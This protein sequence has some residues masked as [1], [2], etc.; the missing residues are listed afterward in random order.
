ML[1]YASCAATEQCVEWE[2]DF[3]TIYTDLSEAKQKFTK[4]LQDYTKR[5][6]KKLKYRGK[7]EYVMCIS[8]KENFRKLVLPTYKSNRT[9]RKPCGYKFLKEWVQ[10]NYRCE[11]RRLLEADDLMGVL[12][13]DHTCVLSGDKD[14][15]TITKGT[16]YDF[17]RDELFELSEEL[18]KYR[19]FYQTLKGDSVD[20]FMGCPGCGDVG[21]RKILD[22]E[23]SWNSVVAAFAKK[24]LTE[25]DALTQ[26]RVARILHAEDYNM[27][28]GEIYLWNPDGTKEVLCPTVEL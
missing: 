10:E 7:Y 16:L 1:L 3:T 15:Q 24:G 23:C 14:Q 4:D 25:T 18:G 21:A 13:N 6:L 27:E 9:K 11:Q 22:K 28:T 5:A 12:A 8:D 2:P 26:A 19:W 17:M 20:G